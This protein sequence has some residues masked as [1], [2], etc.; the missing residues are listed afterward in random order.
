MNY[1]LYK[2]NSYGAVIFVSTF[3]KAARMNGI[4]GSRL[5]E[6]FRLTSFKVFCSVHSVHKDTFFIP[7]TCTRCEPGSS[8][9][10]ATDY[11][12]D[13]PGSNPGWDEIFRR[14]RPAL[15]PIQPPVKWAPGLSRA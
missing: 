6:Q 12:L 4:A 5:R 13:G 8:V 1:C 15:E 10:I 7:T 2:K 11:G 14:S 3:H 9:S